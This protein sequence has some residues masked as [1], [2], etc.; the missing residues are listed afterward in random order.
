MLYIEEMIFRFRS[1]DQQLSPCAGPACLIECL[2]FVIYLYL[3][4]SSQGVWAL[5][6]QGKRISDLSKGSKIP[7]HCWQ[8]KWQDRVGRGT[9]IGIYS[10]ERALLQRKPKYPHSRRVHLQVFLIRRRIDRR[11]PILTSLHL[12]VTFGILGIHILLNSIR[13][14]AVCLH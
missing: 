7:P 1:R 6:C 13:R 3:Y 2:A 10:F 4:D 5:P 8:P 9:G 14:K 11:I 12:Q